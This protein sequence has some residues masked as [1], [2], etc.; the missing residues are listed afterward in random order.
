MKQETEAEKDTELK[1]PTIKV[2][3]FISIVIILKI[4]GNAVQPLV[5]ADISIQAQLADSD[6]SK[7]GYEIYKQVRTY[8]PVAYIL[9]GLL[10][11]KKELKTLFKK[12][13]N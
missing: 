11:F 2:I 7:A 5:M 8:A 10:V 4:I 6:A 3:I 13:A 9:V 1:F 12:G